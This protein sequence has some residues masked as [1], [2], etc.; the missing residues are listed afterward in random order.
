[1][2]RATFAAGCFWGVEDAFRRTPGVVEAVSGYA[3]GH[4][5]HPS[6]EQVCGGNTGHAESV[7]V[8]FDPSKTTYEALVRRFFEIHDPTQLNRQGPDVGAQYRSVIFYHSP[9][10]QE[11]AERVKKELAPQYLPK[12][13]ATS[14]EP[15]KEFWRAEEY[16]QRYAEKHPGR[17]VCHI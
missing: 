7:E 6:Y 8:T 13:I 17:V 14:I 4:I 3:G 2:E 12:T 10:Q 5:A 11:I 1:M 16:H 9:E 15:A